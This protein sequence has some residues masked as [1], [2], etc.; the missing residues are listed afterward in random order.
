MK[1]LG[2]PAEIL[3]G[4]STGT[5]NI[6]SSIEHMTELQAGSYVFMDLDYS[7]IG[8]QESDVYTDFLPALTVLATV[9]SRNHDDR[10]T[11]DAGIKA[12]ATDRSFGPRRE[13]RDWGLFRCGR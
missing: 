6:D 2:M 9:V 11:V 8:G 10:V 3:T 1:R 5:Y 13:I 7:R 4:G 12:F